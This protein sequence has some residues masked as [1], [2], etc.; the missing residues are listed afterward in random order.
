MLRV[1]LWRAPVRHRRYRSLVAWRLTGVTY[2][3]TLKRTYSLSFDT[4][5]TLVQELALPP[6]SLG[7]PN[8]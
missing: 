7:F 3:L 8:P 5:Y 2:S 6:Q 1:H 4:F